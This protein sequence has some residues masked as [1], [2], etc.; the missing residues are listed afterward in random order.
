MS[1]KKNDLY[2][3]IPIDFAK[4]TKFKKMKLL[5]GD[6]EYYN[7]HKISEYYSENIK[8]TIKKEKFKYSSNLIKKCK[9]EKILPK[10]FENVVEKLR[11][12]L[13]E[14]DVSFIEGIFGDFTSVFKTGILTEKIFTQSPLI[15]EN[16]PNLPTAV[17]ERCNDLF[18]YNPKIS[19]SEDTCNTFTE[20]DKE[21]SGFADGFRVIATSTELAIR[22]LS[23]AA[24][25]R[26]TIIY[27]TSY[28]PEERNLLIQIFY[29][30]T[31]K[32]FY[33]FLKDYKDKFRKELSFLYVTKILNL[34]KLIDSK[35]EKDERE[36]EETRKR[37]LCLAIH[38]ALKFIMN[39]PKNNKKFKMILNKI[40][41]DFYDV[42]EKIEEDDYEIEIEDKVPFKFL[43]DELHSEWSNLSI[44]SCDLKED[45]DC[46]LAF[47]K[48]FNKL[49]EHIFLSISIHYPLI[50][51]GGTGK[52]KK[53]AIYYIAKILGYDVIYFNIS[54]S[55][56][57]D[58]LFCKKMPVEENG[59]MIFKDIRSLL[60]DGIDANIEKEKNC[61]IILDNIQQAN[62][63]VLESLIPLFDTNTKSILV[64]GE[65][66]IKRSYNIF[67]IFDS[68][69]ESKSAIDFLPDSIKYSTILYR[70]SNYFNRKYC[71]KIIDKMFG[72][73]ASQ[74]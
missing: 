72:E 10:C 8:H 70:N 59:N 12:N 54:N 69:M 4:R 22:N 33:G 64:Q 13:M 1:I 34:L 25:S 14:F 28:T 63:N 19:L 51:E 9:L 68:S 36:K 42:K 16:L 46:K 20:E 71:R 43:N 29:K 32:E 23:D 73:E 27:T 21:L 2:K 5:L 52:G 7:N 15:A 50:I 65:E 66:V 35:F 40:L 11:K 6:I 26:F 41:P 47:I 62:S 39:T 49:L 57:V 60:L 61:I 31:P 30:D 44:I 74:T 38:C 58:D 55:T 37:N 18:N 45:D 17:I 24:Q 56:S 67:G 48:P 53:S 3:V